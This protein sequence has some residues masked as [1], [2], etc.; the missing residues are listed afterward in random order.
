MLPDL[1]II[2]IV[3]W[4]SESITQKYSGEKKKKNFLFP[5]DSNFSK[6]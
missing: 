6:F 4:I 5:S 3:N 1:Y 2:I